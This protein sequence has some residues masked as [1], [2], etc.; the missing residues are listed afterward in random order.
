VIARRSTSQAAASSFAFTPATCILCWDPA[1]DGKPIRCDVTIDGATPGD[2][3]VV[4]VDA[5]GQGVVTGQRLYQVI[6]QDGTIADHTFEIRFLD[7]GVQAYSLTF[8]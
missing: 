8:G 6:R 2:S 1:P 5:Q 3:H 4:D 7:P